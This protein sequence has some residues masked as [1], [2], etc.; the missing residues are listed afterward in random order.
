[1]APMDGLK[2]G[3]HS[4]PPSWLGEGCRIA[5]TAGSMVETLIKS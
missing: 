2:E 3:G 5:G 4:C 1:L